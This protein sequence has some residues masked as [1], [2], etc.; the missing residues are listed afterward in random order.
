MVATMK[1]GSHIA[2]I[3]DR[4]LR[5]SLRGGTVLWTA[6]VSCIHAAHPSG[7]W[8]GTWFPEGPGIWKQSDIVTFV[9]WLNDREQRA[10]D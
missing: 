2:P 8:L 5:I 10:N 1:L 6:G 3:F 4:P 9:Q 7:A